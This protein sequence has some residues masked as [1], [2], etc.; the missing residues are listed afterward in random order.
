MKK[1][2]ILSVIVCCA[3]G[4][5]TGQSITVK[6]PQAGRNL[7]REAGYSVMDIDNK[8]S[9]AYHD[10]F[11]GPRLPLTIPQVLTPLLQM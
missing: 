3:N 8:I 5:A 10:I 4:L 9:K 6:S 1:L 2:I 11:E 7:F